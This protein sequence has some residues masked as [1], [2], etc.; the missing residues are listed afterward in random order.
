MDRS[1]RYAVFLAAPTDGT[2]DYSV[3][4]WVCL[5]SSYRWT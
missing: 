4:C 3:G 1:T 2:G 5:G